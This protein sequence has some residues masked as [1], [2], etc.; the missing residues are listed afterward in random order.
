MA[1]KTV[2]INKEIVCNICTK[3]TELSNVGESL[4][5]RKSKLETSVG[6]NNGMKRGAYY[7]AY[8]ATDGLYTH[9]TQSL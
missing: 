7:F 1:R 6:E 8:R 2:E 4:Y 9:K 5:K 3:I